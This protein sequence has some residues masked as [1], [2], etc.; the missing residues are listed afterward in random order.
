ME[1]SLGFCHKYLGVTVD[2]TG[3]SNWFIMMLN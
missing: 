2:T 3:I 1:I